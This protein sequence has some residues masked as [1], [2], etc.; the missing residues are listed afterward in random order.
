MDKENTPGEE[1]G[2]GA[3]SAS[4][5]DFDYEKAY[6]ELRPQATQWAQDRSQASERL[7][8]YEQ[9]FEALQDPET[10]GEVL[11]RLGFA[12][13]DGAPQGTENPEPDE[14]EDPLEREIQDLKGTVDD[15]RSQRELEADQ[16]EETELIELRDSYIGDAISFIEQETER[17]FSAQAEEALGNL[18]I[19]MEREDGVPDVQGA[20]N[21]LY[22]ETGV[23]EAERENW[24]ASKTG[25]F[26]AP[27]GRTAPS[28]QN[29]QTPR[30]RAQYF[31]ERLRATEQDY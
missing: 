6:N 7:S 27:G 29:P 28:V 22:G 30:E 8:E 18:A 4:P 20:Y 13:D 11:D 5:D 12:L 17:E 10:Q 19:S 21:L 31:D 9:L 16:Q 3:A 15:L 1:A 24:I 23:L 25:A 2:Q 26:Q 14:W